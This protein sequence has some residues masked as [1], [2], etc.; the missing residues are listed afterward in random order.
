MFRAIIIL[1]LAFKAII[2]YSVW[3]LE[4]SSFLVL[5]FRAIFHAHLGIRCHHLSLVWRPEPLYISLQAPWVIT[6]SCFDVQSHS[7]SSVSFRV[8]GP[9]SHRPRHSYSLALRMLPSWICVYP[10]FPHLVTPCSSPICH[11]PF[12]FPFSLLMTMSFKFTTHTSVM[13][14]DAL[15]LLFSYSSLRVVSF[16]HILSRTSERFDHYSSLTSIF[17]SLWRYLRRSL[18]P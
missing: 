12:I 1:S 9:E 5:A 6:F 17:E 15:H 4:P 18:D 8:T 14:L 16:W 11:C 13:L 2:A 3:R 7:F 10:R